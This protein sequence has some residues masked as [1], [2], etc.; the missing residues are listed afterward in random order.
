MDLRRDMPDMGRIGLIYVSTNMVLDGGSVFQEYS[1]PDGGIY[2]LWLK[3]LRNGDGKVT[4]IWIVPEGTRYAVESSGNVN[5]MVDF[6]TKMRVKYRANVDV[7]EDIDHALL[8]VA[9]GPAP[10]LWNF[11]TLQSENSK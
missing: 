10:A 2:K 4:V 11:A 3:P 1:A 5:I 8:E 6:L 7:R 9:G